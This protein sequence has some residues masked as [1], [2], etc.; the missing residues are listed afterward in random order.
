MRTCRRL[1]IAR[2]PRISWPTGCASR[3]ASRGRRPSPCS[4]HVQPSNS[5]S[6][7]RGLLREGYVADVVVFD[8]ETIGPRLPSALADLPA[9]GTRS[10]ARGRRH[11]RLGGVGPG[12]PGQRRLHRR[13]T[14]SAH[15]GKPA[16]LQLTRGSGGGP[17][18]SRTE[19]SLRIC[20][21]HI[22]SKRPVKFLSRKK[23]PYAAAASGCI[24]FPPPTASMCQACRQRH[25]RHVARR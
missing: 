21:R 2:S 19:G 17:D 15:T 5:V 24:S 22:A 13:S 6:A 16:T 9:G 4:P 14:G 11:P 23:L 12:A 20:M 1:W 7:G 3:S 25:S 8:P 10:G 18:Y